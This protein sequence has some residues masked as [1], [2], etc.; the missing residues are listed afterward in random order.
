M[1]NN[2]EEEFY[3]KVTIDAKVFE[4]ISLL[5]FLA[6]IFALISFGIYKE[7]QKQWDKLNKIEWNLKELNY[8]TEIFKKK[9]NYLKESKNA[10][11]KKE[12]YIR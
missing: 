6:I 9:I 1:K 3:D 8:K 2:L 11:E 5:L 4:Y 7:T 10:L 12:G